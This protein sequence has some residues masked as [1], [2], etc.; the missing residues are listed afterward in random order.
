[1][2]Y[3]KL[4][5]VSARGV[6]YDLNKS[7]WEFTDDLGNVFKFSSQKKLDIFCRKVKSKQAEFF[8]EIEKLQK[9]GYI[10]PKEYENNLPKIPKLVYDKLTE[11]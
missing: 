9:L 5:D 3:N 10:V 11:K 7:P 8:A 6:Y 2:K 1:M 4:K